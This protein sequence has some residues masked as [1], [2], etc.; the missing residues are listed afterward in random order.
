MA[1]I[2]NTEVYWLKESVRASWMPMR[3]EYRDNMQEEIA[4]TME[5]DFRRANILAADKRPAH[6]QFLTWIIVQFDLEF[7]IKAW[8]ELQRYHFIDFVSS[9]SL[10]H[11][12][13]QFD[14][15]KTFNKYVTEE[16]INNMK[17]Y[18]AE[19]KA[20]PTEENKKKLLYNAPLGTEFTARMT[21]NYRQL[22]TMYHQRRDHEL[23]DWQI[24]CDWIDTLP[25]SEW[26]TDDSRLF[27]N[28]LRNK[29][30]NNEH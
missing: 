19:Y 23:D 6:D 27:E 14:L 10:Q 16:T 29:K 2:K 20:N 28:P 8:Y 7:A 9:M 21:T 30:Q 22:R 12:L 18:M 13:T 25:H 24:F 11:R 5:K 15:D 17:K 26:I 4:G 1:W 3:K